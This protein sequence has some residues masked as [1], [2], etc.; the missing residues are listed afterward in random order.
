MMEAS[1]ARVNRDAFE[2]MEQIAAESG[3]AVESYTLLTSDGYALGL[4]RI[5]GTFVDMKVKKPAVLMMHAQDCDQME[6]VWNDSQRANAFIL[7]RAGYDVWMGNNRGSRYSMAHTTLDRHDKKFWDFY[8]EE[9][10][11]IDTPTFIDFILE[12][13]GLEQI[14]YIGHSEGTTQ[15]FLGASLNP[16]YFTEKINLYIAMAPVATT[17]YMGGSWLTSHLRL[18]EF[19]VV[20]VLKYYNWFAPMPQA[21]ELVDVI[22]DTLPSVC[23][24]I[25][26]KLIHNDVDNLERF[27]VFLSNEPS[28]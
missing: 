16:S 26:N 20:D 19:V 5:P 21:V 1:L 10:G 12:K 6:W 4:S 7:A 3:F 23:L 9:M 25:K 28:G 18:I 24:F 8:Q 27:D 11:L 22:C 13:T 17:A 2:T 14:S 15:M